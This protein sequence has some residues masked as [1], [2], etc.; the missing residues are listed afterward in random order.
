MAIKITLDKATI[1][2][3]IKYALAKQ[4]RERNYL[5][6]RCYQ[7]STEIQAFIVDKLIESPTY[8]SLVN[9]SLRADFGLDDSEINNLPNVV[10]SLIYVPIFF[11]D[12]VGYKGKLKN[13]RT[14][15]ELRIGIVP[16]FDTS[17]G[18]KSINNAIEGAQY[19]S[20]GHLIDW[21]TWLL[22]GGIEVV[23]EDYKVYYRP[24]IGRS[25]MAV[26]HGPNG[27]FS[28]NVDPEFAGTVNNNWVTRILDKNKA[29]IFDMIKDTIKVVL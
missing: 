20:N 2:R 13:E 7:L 27:Y 3:K 23:V 28:F 22:F 21:L 14:I 12:A 6:E 9:G 24:G 10:Y 15:F 5:S 11:K 17:Y 25:E 18:R 19:Y 29:D 26:M 16:R 8:D 4:L 1:N